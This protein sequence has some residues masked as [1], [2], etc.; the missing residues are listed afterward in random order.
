MRYEKPA[1][2]RAEHDDCPRA[3]STV[4]RR[5]ETSNKSL[6]LYSLKVSRT[7]SQ[8]LAANCGKARSNGN[9]WPR[10]ETCGVAGRELL[11]GIGATSLQFFG[12]SRSRP[13]SRRLFV[14]GRTQNGD[15]EM[16]EVG[17]IVVQ[18]K[19]AHHAVL[20]EIFGNAGFGNAEMVRE[21]RLERIGAAAACAS[22][23][24]IG[25]GDAKRLAS[26]DVIVRG[27]IRI[28]EQQNAWASRSALCGIQLQR[29]AAQ[30]SAKLHFQKAEPG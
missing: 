4:T 15:H 5:V 30:K 28:A 27:E 24:Q 11:L 23:Q 19:V 18:L 12:K 9:K 29:G 21:L 1:K 8:Y 25:D 2:R 3:S 10:T 14:Q 13:A 26:F 17:S 20:S 16:S 6:N 7:G 22:P